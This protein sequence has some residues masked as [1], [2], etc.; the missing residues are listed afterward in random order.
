[1]RLWNKSRLQVIRNCGMLAIAGIAGCGTVTIT[2]TE[3]W[4]ITSPAN[5][6]NVAR[7]SSITVEGTTGAAVTRTN[8]CSL[9]DTAQQKL[10]G[11]PVTLTVVTAGS[12]DPSGPLSAD[13]SG[14]FKVAC[15]S[16][17]SGYPNGTVAQCHSVDI[18]IQGL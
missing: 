15:G 16:P 2:N 5:G 10:V 1:M 18:H 3:N 13:R 11:S 4:Q 9:F 12:F 7:Y 6:S 14:E 17:I 8:G